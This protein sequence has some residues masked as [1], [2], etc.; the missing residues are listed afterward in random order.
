MDI[1]GLGEEIVKQLVQSGLV[2]SVAG[3]YRLTEEQLLTL[4]RMGKK[5]A[6]NLLAG[7]AAS[8][9]RG[10][11][12]LLASLSIPM[13]GESM[14]ELLT[15]EFPTID[16]LL[17]ASQERIAKIKGFGPTR[18]ESVHDFLHGADGVKLIDELREVGL[19]LSEEKKAVPAGGALL[20][21]KT[22]VVTGTLQKYG[23]EDV[24]GIIKSL[25]G[26]TSG[27]VSGKTDFVLAGESAGSKL[28][29]AKTLGIKVISEEEF[30]RMIGKA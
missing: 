29:K 1:E 8:K 21:G 6:Q 27:S 24:E 2:K 12:R 4:E 11:T 18:A 22:F 28:D 14:A 16:E 5:S 15:Q 9:T 23:R 13:V 26:K 10:L 20:A 7:I 25:G 30:E 17:A 3:L 19:K